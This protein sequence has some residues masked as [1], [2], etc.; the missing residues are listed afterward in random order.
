MAERQYSDKTVT[1]Y[2]QDIH[3]FFKWLDDSGGRIPFD[4]IDHGT[5]DAYLNSLYDHNYARTTVAR[6]ISSLRSFFNY[7]TRQHVVD[8]DPFAYVRLKKHQ[9]HLPRFFY[10]QEMDALFKAAAT[11]SED[12]LLNQRNSAILEVLYGTGIRVGELCLL[13]LP[14]VD[15]Q[16]RSMLIHGKGNKERLVPFGQSAKRALES[17][18]T[19]ARPKLMAKKHLEHPT[20]FVNDLGGPLTEAGVEY[21]LNQVIKQS[22]LTANIH[23][24]MLRHTFATHMLEHGADLRSVQEL[25][26]HSSLSTT[27]I[28]THV[29]RDNLQKSYRQFF[30]R[31]KSTSEQ[32]RKDDLN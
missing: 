18:L 11:G 25:L 19:Q 5:V 21:I 2:Q 20:V 9:D 32:S 3:H 8:K 26:G 28:Y 27:Q 13:T 17:Y 22:S 10:E 6:R 24:H 30:P 23:P 31:A 29:T 15:L 7:L 14:D 16:M 4:Q 12:P 1:A